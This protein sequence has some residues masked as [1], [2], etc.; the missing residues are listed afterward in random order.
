MT[1]NR[2]PTMFARHQAEGRKAFMPFTMLGWPSPERC[3]EIIQALADGGASGLELGVA[4]SD[5]VADGPVIQGVATETIA[6]G[7][8]VPQI[9][10]LLAKTRAQ[11]P[12]LPI[13]L[14]VYTNTVL[15]QG[16]DTFY[17]QAAQAGVDGVLIADLPPELAHEVVPAAQAAGIAPIFIVS[18]L[19][20]PDRLGAMAQ[21]AQGFWYVVSRLG[22]TGLHQ[23]V[24]TAL[25][26]C[27]T[28]LKAVSD[29]PAYVGFGI[30]TPQQAQ[31]MVRLGAD[32]VITG[33][34][35][36]QLV[37]SDPT[38]AQLNTFLTT[39]TQALKPVSASP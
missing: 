17:T 14:L 25:A 8:T 27:L 20:T 13:G 1:T 36:V 7:F 5:P 2:Y 34:K 6:S 23:D 28:Q 10:P 18:P 22:I 38:L 12:D 35:V 30:S 4:F 16:I 21:V 33:S 26:D 19:S 39:M 15:A 29:L 3:W 32:G 31:A 24:D 9:W 11:Y 37:Q